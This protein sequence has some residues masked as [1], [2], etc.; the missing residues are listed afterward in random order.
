ML[1]QCV[2]V[3]SGAAVVFFGSRAKDPAEVR[4][5]VSIPRRI[6]SA[7]RIAAAY[8]SG[9]GVHPA[10]AG[11]RALANAIDLTVL[12]RN[13]IYHQASRKDCRPVR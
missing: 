6:R 1:R 10:D 3:I 5:F 2:V 11:A 8:D 13:H 7:G 9:D 4:F 12:A